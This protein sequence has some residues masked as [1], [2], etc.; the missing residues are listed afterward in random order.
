MPVCVEDQV[1]EVILARHDDVD[2]SAL[3]LGDKWSKHFLQ[4]PLWLVSC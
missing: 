4:G 3:D 1:A 2:V